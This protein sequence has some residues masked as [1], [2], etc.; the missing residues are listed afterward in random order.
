[1]E[2]FCT[3]LALR[4][5]IIDSL[6]RLEDATRIIQK[7][8]LGKGSIGDLIAI[9]R[10][11]DI[12][13][14]ANLIIKAEKAAELD[15]RGPQF[16]AESWESIGV[17]VKRL[18]DLKKLATRIE[19]AVGPREPESSASG[20]SKSEDISNEDSFE[21]EANEHEATPEYIIKPQ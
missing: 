20:D 14:N 13:N 16:K 15:N 18:V 11:I 19:S 12:W 21:G 17:L 1:M 9:R 6:K 8:S 2:L 3:R 10:C 7:F 4:V 5:A